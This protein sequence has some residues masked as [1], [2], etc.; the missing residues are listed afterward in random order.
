MSVNG[1]AVF[2]KI[3]QYSVTV[4]TAHPSKQY[5]MSV[6]KFRSDLGEVAITDSH[7]ERTRENEEEWA[8]IRNS[9]SD[10][11]LLDEAHFSEIEEVEFD[12]GSIYPNIRV[13]TSEGWKRL[14]FHVG[15]QAEKCFRRLKYR[16]NVYRQIYA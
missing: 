10:R 3:Q 6:E 4:N 8:R 9:F 1:L 13:K 11:K 16:L 2:I 15:D 5:C 12:D 7:I 14:F